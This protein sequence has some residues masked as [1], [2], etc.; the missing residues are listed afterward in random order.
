MARQR[1]HKKSRGC[2]INWPVGSHRD[3]AAP[4]PETEARSIALAAVVGIG[5]RERNRDAG[6]RAK[7]MVMST[8]RISRYCIISSAALHYSRNKRGMRSPADLRC[9]I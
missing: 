8:R 3:L 5:G 6:R 1:G 9:A 4:L 7:A 2:E